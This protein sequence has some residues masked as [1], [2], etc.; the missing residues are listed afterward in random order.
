MKSILSAAALFAVAAVPAFAGEAAAPQTQSATE[1]IIPAAAT[2][3]SGEPVPV[4][5]E[6]QSKAA[7]KG[8]GCGSRQSVYL[9][10]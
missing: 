5:E 10:N 3:A 7:V 8:H 1:I 6:S 9:T 4:V 2:P